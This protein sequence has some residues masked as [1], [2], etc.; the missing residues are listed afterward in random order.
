VHAWI[1][2]RTTLERV[3]L[4]VDATGLRR[5]TAWA[6]QFSPHK[7]V[8]D[9]RG[10]DSLAG[11]YADAATADEAYAM[12]I[13]PLRSKIRY[14][15]L[16]IVPHRELHYVPFAALHDAKRN[17]FLIEDYRISYAPS[18]SAW[19][20][21]RRSKPP[22]ASRALVLGD[23]AGSMDALKQASREAKLVASR[24]GTTA[25]LGTDAC[26]S[27]IHDLYSQVDLLHI[28]AHA[29]YDGANPLFSFIALAPD[30][31]EY[32]G[33]LEAQEILAEVDLTNVSLVVVSACKTAFGDPSA[34]DEIVGL[35]RALL[36]AGTPAVV[37]TLWEIDDTATTVLMDAFYDRFVSGVPVAD[38]LREAQLSMLRGQAFKSPGSWAAFTLHGN[39]EVTWRRPLEQS[40]QPPRTVSESSGVLSGGQF[41]G[42]RARLTY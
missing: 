29:R 28:A 2:D 18:A 22:V 27:L 24:L 16:L 12:L 31:D 37:S 33:N 13:A 3:R 42:R 21:L 20:F 32:D 9:V 7:K 17:R 4:P 34:G 25:L 15:R 14:Q 10:A 6:R 38:A 19:R 1:I 26:E 40:R 30:G 5:L 8:L 11:T 35:T 36:Y 39:P 41:N 23:P